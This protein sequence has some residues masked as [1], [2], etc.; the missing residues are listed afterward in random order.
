MPNALIDEREIPDDRPHYRL[1]YT[2]PARVTIEADSCG[3]CPDGGAP[4]RFSTRLTCSRCGWTNRRRE[5]PEK[6]RRRFP[7]LRQRDV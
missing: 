3:R 7:Q 5:P 1:P 4:V 2:P 6:P